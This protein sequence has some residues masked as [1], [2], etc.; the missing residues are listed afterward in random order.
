[1][2]NHLVH[3]T[4]PYLL[5]HAENPVN[6]YAWGDEAFEKAKL[7]NKPIF[8]SIGYSTCHWCHVMA[9]E[10]FEDDEVASLLN[11]GFVSIKVDKEERPDIDSVYMS[12]CQAMTGSGG[13]PLTIVMTPDAKPFFSGTYFPKHSYPQTAG[14]IDILKLISDKWQNEREKLIASGNE[15]AQ[16]LSKETAHDENSFSDEITKNTAHLLRMM[17]D[18][19]NGGFTQKP[20]FPTPQNI[21]F[22]LRHYAFT[23]EEESLKMAEKTLIQMYRGGIWDHIGFGFSRYAT[24][25][26]WL[27]PHFEKMLYDNALLLI[28]YAEAY[29]ITKNPV[30]KTTAE[31][32]F[33]YLQREMQDESGGFY[34]AQDADSDGEEGKYYVFSKEELLHILGKENGE[35]FCAFYGITKLGNFEGKSIPNLLEN[36][37]YDEI[38]SD[39][40]IMR[41]QIYEY[42]KTRTVLGKDDKILSAWNGLAISGLSVAG[43][44]LGNT[45]MIGAA[46]KARRF[47]K[48]TM[49]DRRGMLFVSYRNAQTKGMGHLDDYAFCVWGLLELYNA[50]FHTECLSDAL[51]L[52]DMMVR[53]FFDE[54]HGGFWLYAESAEQLF[55]RPKDVYDG[56]IP[57]GNSAAAYV[58]WKISALSSNS[59]YMEQTKKQLDFLAREIAEF[60]AGYC[61]AALAG[62]MSLHPSKELICIFEKQ[63]KMDEL[64]QFL[65]DRFMPELNVLYLN[66]EN[67]AE[68]TRLMPF[69]KNYL[70][71]D[72]TTTYYLCENNACHTP[73]HTLKDIETALRGVKTK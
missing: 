13:W 39:I 16:I 58:M 42:R 51:E 54:S 24:D 47:I 43:R 17:F 32:I 65:N 71:A 11:N 18:A 10:S 53:E 49:I 28:A 52:Y 30:Y 46:E 26:R 61:F 56:A 20:K 72:E 3:E 1:M 57:S 4:S 27:I 15:I 62:M 70:T 41:N 7:E 50:T 34:C 66:T 73:V 25:Q 19:Q 48:N 44:I 8:L 2:T 37:L 5:Q 36:S 35:R 45:D 31:Q 33:I 55:L 38:P 40:A 60:P 23:N 63:E 9:H 12:V 6:W 64:Q 69:L 14:L 59:D 21:L 22:L 67:Q 29:Q 68:M